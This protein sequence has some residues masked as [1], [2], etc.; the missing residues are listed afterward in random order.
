MGIDSISPHAPDFNMSLW[1]VVLTGIADE[2]YVENVM[3]AYDE[4]SASTRYI[5]LTLTR[6]RLEKLQSQQTNELV[7]N[8]E[9][10]GVISK[11]HG[12]NIGEWDL[13]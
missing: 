4:V 7:L 2:T 12:E 13:T 5:P 8:I 3:M 10:R 9:Y 6:T 1:H 11:R